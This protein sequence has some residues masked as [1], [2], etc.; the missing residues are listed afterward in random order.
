MSVIVKIIKITHYQLIPPIKKRIGFTSLGL[1]LL[2]SVL[3][4]ICTNQFQ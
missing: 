1:V 3:P 4:K 2:E